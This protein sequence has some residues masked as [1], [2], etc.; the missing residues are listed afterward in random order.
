MKKLELLA[1][2]TGIKLVD[3]ENLNNYKS[4]QKDCPAMYND[5]CTDEERLMTVFSMIRIVNVDYNTDNRFGLGGEIKGEFTQMLL[6]KGYSKREVRKI[7]RETF[8]GNNDTD[9]Y[10]EF[11]LRR[12]EEKIN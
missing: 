12:L 2:V 7:R 3:L 11:A 4:Y 10:Y 9:G 8:M 6:E 5:N 1:K